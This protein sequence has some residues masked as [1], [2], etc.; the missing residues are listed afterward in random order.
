MSSSDSS[1][2]A[3]YFEPWKSRTVKF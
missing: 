3:M 2:H 1:L